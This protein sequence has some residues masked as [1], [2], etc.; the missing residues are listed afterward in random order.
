MVRAKVYGK[1]RTLHQAFIAPVKRG[2]PKTTVYL[3]KT[4]KRLPLKMLYGPGIKQ[5]FKQK[6]NDRI[7]QAKVREV[8]PREF[9]Q[10]MIFA[11]KRLKMPLSR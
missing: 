7:M 3:R 4:A 1:V 8:F 5:L 9:E 6:E 10:N 11:L 2:S